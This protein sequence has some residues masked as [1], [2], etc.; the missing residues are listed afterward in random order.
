[1]K[2]MRTIMLCFVAIVASVTVYAQKIKASGN[3]GD[4]GSVKEYKFDFIYEDVKVGKFDNEEEYIEKK[5]AEYN[6]KEPGSGDKWKVSWKEDRENRY[7]GKFEELFNDV[8]AKQGV[9]GERSIDSENVV[10]IYTTFIEPGFNVG[11][12]RKNA[13]VSLKLVFLKGGQEVGTMTVEN[14]PGA[15]ALG[16]DFDT[17]LRISEAYAK[18]GKEVG[19]YLAKKV[20]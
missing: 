14:S 9:K 16:Y 10:K 19:K 12:M 2:T 8:L 3:L 7:H 5:V 18:A 1:M 13:M 6:E 20:Y 17:G 4:L 11:V 15:T